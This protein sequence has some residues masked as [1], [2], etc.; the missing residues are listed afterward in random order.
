MSELKNEKLKKDVSSRLLQDE[1]ELAL[2]I[3]KSIESKGNIDSN[4][5]KKISNKI[6]ENRGNS[7]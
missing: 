6:L 3:L 4:E 2:E 1:A 7:K 5:I